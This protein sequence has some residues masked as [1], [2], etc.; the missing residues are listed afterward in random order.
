MQPII[1]MHFVSMWYKAVKILVDLLLDIEIWYYLCMLCIIV[2]LNAIYIMQMDILY[3]RHNILHTHCIVINSLL[4]DVEACPK[5][6][7]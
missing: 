1:R 4:A 5:P 3:Y 7:E 6:V 2:T